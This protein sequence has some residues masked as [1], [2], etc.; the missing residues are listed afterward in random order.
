MLRALEQ[1][2]G[3]KVTR[4]PYPGLMGAI[5]AALLTKERAAEKERTFIGLDALESFTYT[6]ETNSPCPFCT[7]HCK[8]AIV[9]FSNGKSW[10]TNN[11]C[12]RGEILGDPRMRRCA[13][14]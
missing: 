12:E 2:I 3:K 5:G 10:V 8:R 13:A 1:Y 9:T 6:Q 14:G 4:A 11:R 7:N